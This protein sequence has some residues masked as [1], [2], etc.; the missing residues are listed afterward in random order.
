MKHKTSGFQTILSSGGAADAVVGAGVLRNLV[1][2][3]RG[4]IEIMPGGGVRASNMRLLISQTGAAWYHS[5]AISDAG[6]DV[7]ES[8]VIRLREALTNQKDWNSMVPLCELRC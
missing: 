8:E 5:S 6:E 3:A 2:R 7:D 1:Q 4:R